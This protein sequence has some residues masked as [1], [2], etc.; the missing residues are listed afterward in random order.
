MSEAVI[1][2][3]CDAEQGDCHNGG[4]PGVWWTKDETQFLVRCD[5]CNKSF[6]VEASWT[7][8]FYCYKPE[9]YQR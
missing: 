2:P 8:S 3:H 5:E 6:H 9:A 7:V 1:C 4:D